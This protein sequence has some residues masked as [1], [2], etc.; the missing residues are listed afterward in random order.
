LTDGELISPPWLDLPYSLGDVESA[1]TAVLRAP[2]RGRDHG[3]FPPVPPSFMDAAAAWVAND[4]NDEAPVWALIGAS[5]VR[6]KARWAG[7]AA[8]AARAVHV[9][10]MAGDPASTARL[11]T[12]DSGSGLHLAGGGP[13]A[14][15]QQLSEEADALAAMAERVAAD[16][17]YA[18]IHFAPRFERE[19][20]PLWGVDRNDRAAWDVFTSVSAEWAYDAAPFQLLGPAHLARLSP[21]QRDACTPV[22]GADERWVLRLGS[23]SDWLADE[24]EARRHARAALQGVIIDDESSRKLTTGPARPPQ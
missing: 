2:V 17:N 20:A 3:W 22:P 10:L 7:E 13:A 18:A 8:A 15:P 4:G 9:C 11:V 16:V 19:H 24:P 5:T 21:A 12:V 14:D 1:P 23:W 6:T